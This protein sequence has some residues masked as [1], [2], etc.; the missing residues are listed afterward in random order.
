V[1]SWKLPPRVKVFE[2]LSA[3][4]DGRVRLAGPGSAT[5][6]SSGGDKVYAVEWSDD[7]RTIAA[8]DNA[9]YWR[10]YL[11]Y[12]AL[13]VLLARG[14]LKAGEDVVRAL[15]GVPWHDLNTRFKRDYDAAVAH[16]LADLPDGAPGAAGV[17]PRGPEVA[18][19]APG[20]GGSR[21]QH[22]LAAW[23]D[24]RRCVATSR[25][26]RRRSSRV[27]RLRL[28]LHHGEEATR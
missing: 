27:G 15:A 24:A 25:C 12:P 5:V 1:G 28:A 4:A 3:V 17:R 26:H 19:G 2:A 22:L 21:R 13:A 8:N 18:S 20:R 23:G 11:G 6:T 9:S 7:G 14:E 10:G 16:V